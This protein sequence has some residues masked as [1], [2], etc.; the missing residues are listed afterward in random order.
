MA[1]GQ[2]ACQLSG[3]LLARRSPV[4]LMTGRVQRG[5]AAMASGSSFAIGV[6]LLSA[7]VL[8]RLYS[9]DQYGVYAFILSIAAILAVASSLRCEMAIASAP[10]DAEAGEA[11]KAAVSSIVVISL[12]VAA[13][14][15]VTGAAIDDG[16]GLA[17]MP[18]L[19]LTPVVAAGIALTSV[20][21]QLATRARNYPAI[22]GRT[23]VQ[24]V[25]VNGLQITA[26]AV[27]PSP[28]GLL[29]GDAVGRL[30]SLVGFVPDARRLWNAA[31]PLRPS[32]AAPRLRTFAVHFTPAALL[33]STAAQL[34]LLLVGI[35]Y[36]P[37]PAG[38]LALAYRVAGVPATVLGNTISQVVMGELSA[39]LRAGQANNRDLYLK[40]T[41]RLG[42]V[43]PVVLMAMI[44]LPPVVFGPLFGEAWAQAASYVQVIA[45]AAAA[46]LIVSPLE[47]LFM[48]YR[49]G[50]A[51]LQQD[52]ARVILLLGGGIAALL[53]G[54]PVLICLALLSC[55]QVGI[56]I[57]VWVRGLKLVS[58]EEPRG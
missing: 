7:P 38:L 18:W 32:A 37:V 4:V 57:V 3:A 2:G 6:S 22:A 9:P 5:A 58:Q 21:T 25:G 44:A 47:P 17:L 41:R 28:G 36:G 45:P 35:G 56:Y 39:R 29:I 26:G 15:A 10:S 52:A 23:A 50:P 24:T 40:A 13:A 48:V 51:K 34:P 49:E 16:N 19:L 42:L 53:A 11:L 14:L 43:A 20:C 12:A 55:V 33:N 46:G 27:S 1:C 30:T 8:T 31:G 54:V